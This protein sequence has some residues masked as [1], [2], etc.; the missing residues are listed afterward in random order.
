[1]CAVYQ[2]HVQPQNVAAQVGQLGGAPLNDL[3]PAWVDLAV[4]RLNFDLHPV[5]N[6]RCQ[7]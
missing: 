6:L 1:M 5:L 2:R 4:L 7:R 3:S